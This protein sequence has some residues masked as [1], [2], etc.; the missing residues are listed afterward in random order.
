MGECG[1][2][3]VVVCMGIWK[4]CVW[5]Y[6]AHTNKITNMTYIPKYMCVGS[7]ITRI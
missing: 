7:D 2:C 1:G 3:V 5:E 6:D 4:V